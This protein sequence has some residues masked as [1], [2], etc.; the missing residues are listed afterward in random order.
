MD[1]ALITGSCGLVGAECV[2]LFSKRQFKVAGI[3]NDMRRV[4]FGPEASTLW[5]RKMLQEEIQGYTHYDLDIR[6]QTAVENLFK[7]YG[8]DI[9]LIIHAAAQPSHDWAASDPYTDFSI[10]ASATLSLLEMTRRYCPD[11]IFIFCST[12]K[13]Y[14]D[15]PNRLPLVECETRWELENS[16]PYYESGI[17]ET[18]SIDQNLHSLFGASKVAADVL[19]QEYGRYFNMKTACFRGGCLTG[20]LHSGAA[21]HGFLSYLM[22]CAISGEPYTVFGY[23]AKQVRDNIHSYDLASAFYEFY[24]APGN[25]GVYNIGGS[26]FS[27][28]SVLEAIRLCEEITGKKVNWTYQEKN[29][30]GDHIWWISGVRKFQ[31]HYPQWV[32]TYDI[33]KTLVEIYGHFVR[34]L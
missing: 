10:N 5:C 27:N 33:R 17:D 15:M 30:A 28:C 26:R 13:V 4:F 12:N 34:R 29:R 1:T 32:L 23:K 19:V 31:S 3:D 22:K 14:G 7:D 24:K 9:K 21:L 6:D 11:A 25:G 18:M 20:P 2:R 16:H 8:T